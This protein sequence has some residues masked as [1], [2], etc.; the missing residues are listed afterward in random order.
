MR[1]AQRGY[2]QAEEI[3]KTLGKER[4][5]PV[6]NILKRIKNTPFQSAIAAELRAS[7]VK[8]A[9]ALKHP[10]YGRP[11]FVT[12]VHNQWHVVQADA[13]GNLAAGPRFNWKE[14]K[15]RATSA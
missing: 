10:K 15:K 3:A 14:F 4:Q 9:F 7:N 13:D 5:V 6:A 12:E 1:H 2:N 11:V 8:E